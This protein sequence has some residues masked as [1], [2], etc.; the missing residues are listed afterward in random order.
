M[1]I[2]QNCGVF[3]ENRNAQNTSKISD[4]IKSS[5]VIH[6]QHLNGRISFLT[7]QLKMANETK[8]HLQRNLTDRENTIV[9]L[10]ENN[11]DLKKEI[12]NFKSQQTDNTKSN[13]KHTN[14]EKTEYSRLKRQNSLNQFE[15]RD[16]NNQLLYFLRDRKQ[17][18][19]FDPE[20]STVSTIAT[21]RRK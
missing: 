20:K 19:V 1:K 17:H 10:K 11:N 13:I 3:S 16:L 9:N 4:K 18:L 8:E 6:T 21:L 14:N 12:E 7:Q 5:F 2:Y 15:V